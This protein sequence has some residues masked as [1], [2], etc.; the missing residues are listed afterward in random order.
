MTTPST[1]RKAGP[2]LG[3]GAQ[4][5]WPFTF[6]VFAASDIAVTIADSLGVETALVYGVDFN[7]TLNANQE[8][9]PGGTVTY[10]ISGAALSVGKRLVIIGNLPYDQPLDLPS[11]GNFSPLAI[12]N[13]L[14]R[15]VMQ[16]QQLA[17][18]A[19]RA[20][21]VSITTSADVTLPPPAASQLIG[22]DSTGENLENV[23]L[24]EL[25][26][27]I[28]YGTYR[29]DTFTGDGTT[30]NFALS[31]DPAVLANL[32]VS[33][34][35]VV[36]VPGT[37]YSLVTGNLVFASAPSNGTTILA[38]YGQ[39]LTALPDSD[40][41]TFVQ[42][43]TGAV[44]RTVQNKLRESV[45]VKDFGAVGDG[46]ADDT[47]AILLAF[48]NGGH[49]VFPKGTYKVTTVLCQNITGLTVD[50]RSATFTS[51]YGNVFVFKGCDDFAWFGG[52]INAGAI[53]NPALT[54]SPELYPQNF[55]VFDANRIILSEMTVVN[56]PVN[57]LP[58]ITAWNVG[59]TQINNNQVFYGGDNSIWVFGGSHVTVSNNLVLNQERG[60]GICFQQVNFGAITGNVCANGKGDGCN[61]HGS[62]NIA[63]T[64]NSVYDMAVDT[65]LLGL[66]SGISIEWDENAQPASV[67][68]AVANPQL[69]NNVFSRNI[70]VSGN[71]IS[72]TQ[73]GVRVGNNVGI[74][75][76]SY[77]NQGQ[78]VIDG[79]NIF[80]VGIGISTGTSRQL[81]ISNN[82]I[83]TCNQGCI[84]VNMGT[85][86]GGYSS[87]D[88]YVSNNRFTIFNVNNL[89]YNA[90]Q[91]NNGTPT[92][93]DRIILTNNEWDQGNFA[94]GFTNV[95]GAA[96]SV[97][98]S[99]TS[100]ANGVATSTTKSA[101]VVQRQ[102]SDQAGASTLAPYFIGKASNEFTQ[103]GQLGDS[104]TTVLAIPANASIAAQIQIGTFDR[105]V[106]FG[107][108][109]AHNGTTPALT[110]T[111][112]GASYVQLSG[113][114]LQ[115]KGNTS[116]GAAT[117]GGLYSIRYSLLNPS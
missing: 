50:A 70:V 101:L 7:V 19:G 117:Y 10:P 42:A 38:R 8:T 75:G 40:Q 99:N 25:A 110:F 109:Y 67:A 34:S 26:T 104:F 103:S 57:P 114:N 71:T 106:C 86:S 36:Q 39:A 20:L 52:I 33:I 1:P 24:S 97:M 49:V 53:P 83:S 116:A 64:G 87:E 48:Q 16:I 115:I 108:I 54:N 9:S 18:K 73:T 91:F 3:T 58:C 4:T 79:N 11:G 113:G 62:S 94:A 112:T 22:W 30:T 47:A 89:G 29:Y 98:D 63:I 14:D 32:D 27:A 92:A 43:G 5:S 74:T 45:S 23:P 90:V 37:D 15:T 41:I 31:E 80:G 84:E 46:V 105:V 51:V 85:D 35:G 76:F 21:Q 82:M 72:K 95:S 88:V 17:E 61:V 100:Y 68:A 111:G 59:Q 12:E 69:Y 56:N 77:G 55:L 60:R 28:A 78:V 93:S 96:L 102:F 6:K 2:L 81:R 66:S 107:T 44:T 65:V 13:Q